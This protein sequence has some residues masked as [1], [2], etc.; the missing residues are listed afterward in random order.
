MEIDFN[1]RGSWFQVKERT[2]M[3]I[4]YELS[5]CRSSI[6]VW[7]VHKRNKKQL[8]AFFQLHVENWYAKKIT[9]SMIHIFNLQYI[10]PL[11]FNTNL[12]F[13]LLHHSKLWQQTWIIAFKLIIPVPP[14]W[15]DKPSNQEVTLGQ[16]LELPCTADGAPQPKITWRKEIGM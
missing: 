3:I 7:H 1:T 16:R 12:G 2:Q 9:Q 4:I 8:L 6:L 10:R 11:Y 14:T 15:K 5:F 13:Y